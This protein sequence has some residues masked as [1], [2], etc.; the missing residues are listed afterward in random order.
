MGKAT[1]LSVPATQ[2]DVTGVIDQGCEFE[3]KLCFHGTVRINGS[4]RGQIYTPDTLIVGREG[5]IQG[6]ID[7]GVVIISGEVTGNVHA[8]RR[9]EIHHPAIFRGD[10]YTPSLRVDEGVIFEGSSKMVHS[11]ED[12]PSTDLSI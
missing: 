12:E 7:A 1:D 10:I 6:D 3:G 5:R 8:K 4:F 2:Y 9:V 11:P